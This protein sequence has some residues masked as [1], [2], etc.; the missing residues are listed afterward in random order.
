MRFLLS[1]RWVLFALVVVL[2]AWLAVQLGQWQFHRLDDRQQR[3][4]H[5]RHQPGPSARPR[6]RGAVDATRP[7]ASRTS[8]GGSRCTGRG[9]TSTRSCSS[10]RPATRVPGWT[11]SR[12]WS[13]TTAPPCSWTVAGWP[14]NNSGASRPELPEVTPGQVT[15]T[16]WVR[17]DATGS[18]TKVSDDLSTRAISSSALA[19]VT[20]VPALPR[21]RRPRRGEPGAGD[22]ARSRPS[23][24]TTPATGRTSSTGCS[25]GSSGRWRSSGSST[26]PGTRPGSV[27]RSA[28]AGEVARASP[29]SDR[30]CRRPR[31]ASRR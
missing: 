3:Q 20:A 4:P 11:W 28:K 26:S 10:T 5:R 15:V 1:R 31:A 22:R 30:T 16:G 27:G 18:A 24:P 9:T 23:C 12:R 13:P 19:E 8:G 21:L 7:P 29:Q 17:R 2:L 14:P 6:R 25:G